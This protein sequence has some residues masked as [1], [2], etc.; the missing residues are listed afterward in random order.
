MEAS[1][2]GS[3]DRSREAEKSIYQRWGIGFLALPVLLATVLMALAFTQP[4]ASNLVSEAV[5][6]E[7]ANAYLAPQIAPTQIAQ[8]KEIRTVGAN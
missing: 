6:A 8:P 2:H 3:F 1:M 5:Q 7:F 4:A